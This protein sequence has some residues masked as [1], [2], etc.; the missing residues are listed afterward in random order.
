MRT[1]YRPHSEGCG[2]VMFL[3]PSVQLQEGFHGLWT[4]VLSC[5]VPQPV[6][7]GRGIV[8]DPPPSRRSTLNRVS[9]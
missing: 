8:L 2:K 5:K 4:Q 6:D 3:Y 9:R 7:E 1:C